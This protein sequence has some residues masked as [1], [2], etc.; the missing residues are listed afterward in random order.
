MPQLDKYL[1]TLDVK[2][3]DNILAQ[4]DK[5]RKS[6]KDMSK[7]KTVVDLIAQTK[8][9]SG[10]VVS[11]KIAKQ[12]KAGKQTPEKVVEQERGS[13][14]GTSAKTVGQVKADKNTPEK[15]VEQ[16]RGSEKRTPAKLVEQE[17]EST[18]TSK[19]LK[20][21][22]KD[23]ADGDKKLKQFTKDTNAGSKGQ[24][25]SSKEIKESTKTE[26][27]SALSKFSKTAVG[28]AG[29]T[30][31][32]AANVNVAGVVQGVA[33]MFAKAGAAGMIIGAA[34]KIITTG[35]SKG[36]EIGKTSSAEANY[37]NTRNAATLYYGGQHTE[38]YKDEKGKTKSYQA[39]NISQGLLSNA[40]MAQ[41]TASVSGSFGRLQKPMTDVL[42]KYIK[43][44]TKDTGALAQAASGNWKS[45][46]TDKGFFL[47]KLSDSFGDLPPSIAQK[48]QS[49]L[50]ENYGSEVQNATGAQQGA[51][52]NNAKWNK[53]EEDQS[54]G[55]YGAAKK[56]MDEMIA[57]N[58]RNLD[59]EMMLNKGTLMLSGSL[60]KAFTAV[61]TF[62]NAV[63]NHAD[64]VIKKTLELGKQIENTTGSVIRFG[65]AVL[66]NTSKV[67]AAQVKNK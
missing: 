37:L 35:M 46:G 61:D 5:I 15:I 28:G 4:M 13:G 38:T 12:G 31:H 55:I 22:S 11:E 10:I 47:Q 6:G 42:S 49:R 41:L 65:T 53:Q 63:V 45:T 32:A 59:A 18:K 20:A 29:D 33:G 21:L 23:L 30:A 66:T 8:K 25:Q 51:Q 27:E 26:K 44:G 39:S 14:K 48:F 54:L 67:N 24:K 1:V 3:Q 17:K 16:E 34:A 40:E 9:N 58:A 7:K 57:L 50:L 43:G 2:G 52:Y 56:R 60:E 19:G 64:V 36:P 62:N